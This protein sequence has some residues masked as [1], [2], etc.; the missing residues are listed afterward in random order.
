MTNANI[1]FL[2]WHSP[3]WVRSAPFPNPFAG[4]H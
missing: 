3:L 1:R 2:D 4:E